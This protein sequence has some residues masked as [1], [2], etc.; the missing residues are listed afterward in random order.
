MEL[1]ITENKK[2]KGIELSFSEELPQ[3]LAT[4][5]KELGFKEALRNPLKWYADAH[6]AY[7]KFAT[8]LSEVLSNNGDWET[9]NIYHSFKPSLENI[10]ANKFS[11]ITIYFQGTEK[12]QQQDYVLFDSYKKVALE[13]ATHFAMIQYG[14]ALKH[15]EVYPRNYK[16]KARELFKEGKIIQRVPQEE[17]ESIKEGLPLEKDNV[18][19]TE[20]NKPE[21]AKP[22]ANLLRETTVSVIETLEELEKNLEGEAET[23]IAT[24]INDLEEA[25]EQTRELPFKNHLNK[26]VLIFKDWVNDLDADTRLI[27]TVA[28]SKLT[29][30]LD[31]API[32]SDNSK[33]ESLVT[34]KDIFNRDNIIPNV[35]VPSQA[36]EPFQSGG[37]N[38]GDGNF[39][40]FKF[41]QLYKINDDTLS[42][43]SPLALFQLSQMAHP[44]DYG[45]FVNRSALLREWESR[46]REAFETLGFPTDL[47]YPYV[48]IHTGY[49]SVSTLASEIGAYDDRHQW[50]SAVEHSRPVADLEK[51]III[52]DD[53]LLKLVEQQTEYINPKTNKPKTDKKSKEA[54][55]DIEWEINRLERSKRVIVDYLENHKSKS[56][57]PTIPEPK[58]SK[59][60]EVPNDYLDKVIAIMHIAF[61]KAE[62]L[63]KKK[64]EKLKEETNAPTMGALW[65]AV[66]LSWLL[67][68][69]MLYKEPISFELRLKKMVQFWNN[70]QPTY[71]YSDSSKELYKQYSTPCPI[72]AIVAQYTGMDKAEFIFEPSAGNGLL[73]VGANPRI[74]HVNEIDK[75]RKQSLEYQGFGRITS[76]NAAEP[77]PEMMHKVHDVVVTN[78]PFASWDDTKFDKERIIQKYFH[79]HRGLAN[80]IRLEH[81][82][83]GLALYTMKDDGKAAII[84]MGHVYF[85]DDGLFAKYRPFFNWLY[86]HYK[87]DDIINMNSYKLYNKQGAVTKTMLILIGG[88]KAT[89]AGVAP[90]KSEQPHLEDM[91]ETFED[92]WMR[93]KSHI[94]PNIDTIIQQLK[95]AQT[96]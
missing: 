9:V 4:F 69:K 10:D 70:V 77:F 67:W 33:D 28:M 40:K 83:A 75:S 91:V 3:K 6:P 86:R 51:G 27:A 41:P 29:Q 49:K 61:T 18:V 52:I 60:K 47:D 15:I 96:Q 76:E 89:P 95:T 57:V 78:P 92:L 5:L 39:L 19:T 72:G 31:G 82:M 32:D 73:L 25:L 53:L 21:T 45:M 2:K 88:R 16:R 94:K 90:N 37:L 64:I 56:P 80:H 24:T 30:L 20:E 35:L 12:A 8:S 50:W 42:Q 48:N 1:S 26:A 85:G 7:Q 14:D 65:E 63:S 68:Y 23:I 22:K 62:R 13:I 43:V 38:I 36:G 59:Q 11:V 71:A 55:N 93:T 74:T 54:F 66:E 46:G 87:V 81:L 79:K 34:V 44:K 58:P 84:I 17:I